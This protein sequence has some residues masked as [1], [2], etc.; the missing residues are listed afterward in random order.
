MKSLYACIEINRKMNKVG[1][2]VTERVKYYKTKDEL[3]GIEVVKD[4]NLPDKEENVQDILQITEDEKEIDSILDILVSNMVMYNFED[5]I[6]DLII[7]RL[8][9]TN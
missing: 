1:N 3:Y 2:V 8:C 4:N 9:T 6:N 5:I 7:N